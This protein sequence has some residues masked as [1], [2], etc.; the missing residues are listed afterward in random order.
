MAL[1]SFKSTAGLS[2][3]FTEKLIKLPLNKQ[4]SRSRTRLCLAVFNLPEHTNA[5]DRRSRAK[6]GDHSTFKNVSWDE[7]LWGYLGLSLTLTEASRAKTYDRQ[8]NPAI[9]PQQTGAISDLCRNFSR[10]WMF[11][12]WISILGIATAEIASRSATLVWV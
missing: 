11:D 2:L 3:A 4:K 8:P 12:K 5:K 1:I 7:H 10:A 6:A 9:C